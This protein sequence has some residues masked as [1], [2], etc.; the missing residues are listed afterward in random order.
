MISP[1]RERQSA[2]DWQ[3]EV[4]DELVRHDPAS[5]FGHGPIQE[6]LWDKR[7]RLGSEYADPQRLTLDLG[8]GNGVVARQI[9]QRTGGRVLGFDIS[10]ECV[11]YAQAYNADPRIEYRHASI[12]SSEPGEPCGL[13][14]MYEVLEHVD[15]PG[16]VLRRIAGWLGPG[17]H[18]VLS[19][20]NRSS[21]NRR[22]KQLPLLR[23]LYAHTSS[24]APDEVSP[25][26]VD[27]YHYRELVA[28]I[29]SAGL[30]LE[31]ALGAVLIMPF[32]EA[33]GVLARSRR[34]AALNVRSGDWM[35]Q[36]AG[37]AYLVARAPG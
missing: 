26:H 24:R 34:F 18:L 2:C 20:P 10:S 31:R 12:E 19:T 22:L 37:H 30:V 8:C 9:A 35:P 15:D 3:E 7:I 17:G 4:F 25:G 21:L 11:A 28:M 14:T 33:V 32:P 6:V 23:G 16:A 36:L 29:E 1:Q 27:E 5:A 13:V